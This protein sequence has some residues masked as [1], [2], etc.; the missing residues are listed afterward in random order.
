MKNINR[1]KTGLISVFLHTILSYTLV[2]GQSYTVVFKY[3]AAGNRVERT[4]QIILPKSATM[5]L[6]DTTDL[7]ESF[8]FDAE[9]FI[10]DGE[11]E[12]YK[13]GENF[14]IHPNPTNGKLV[15]EILE[16]PEK[17]NI[18][19]ISLSDA[20]GNTIFTKRG[21]FAY[22]VFDLG[23]YVPG[24]YILEYKAGKTHKRWKILKQ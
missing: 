11:H 12:K 17:P 18:A 10:N 15:L 22:N 24:L 20:S 23:L 3:D 4:S 8:D 2:Y 7:F 13:T 21:V 1:L 5:V 19:R 9:Q 16:L 14:I 6:D